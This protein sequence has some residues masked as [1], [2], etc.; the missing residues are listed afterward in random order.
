MDRA[1]P[2]NPET[3]ENRHGYLDTAGGLINRD[4]DR[5]KHDFT[6]LP[7]QRH[8]QLAFATTFSVEYLN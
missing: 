2:P 8:I 3:G 6:N 1:T 4:L 5:Y 7:T